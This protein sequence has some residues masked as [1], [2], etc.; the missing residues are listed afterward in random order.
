MDEDCVVRLSSGTAAKTYKGF[1]APYLAPIA[2]MAVMPRAMQ[3][4][5]MRGIHEEL[6]PDR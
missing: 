4:F 1:V 5:N 6:F 2:T 3:G